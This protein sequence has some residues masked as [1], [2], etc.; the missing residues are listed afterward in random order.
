MT[1]VNDYNQGLIKLPI[2][3][4]TSMTAGQGLIWGVDATST[5]TCCLINMANKADNIFAILEE[6]PSLVASNIGTPLVYQ[7]LCSL[8]VNSRVHKVYYDQN[9]S[10]DLDVSSSTSTVLT[11]A[12]MDDNLDASWLYIQ[13]GTGAGQLRYIKAADTTT[14]TVNTAFTTTPD[15]TSD[16]II[17]RNVGI[18]T[19]GT[20]FNTTFDKFLAALDNTTAQKCIVLKN[21]CEG[22]FGVVEMDVNRNGFLEADGLQN[23]GV[24]FFSHI[25]FFDTEI[26]ATGL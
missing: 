26:A 22:P 14:L 8:V 16:F 2:Y 15:A 11:A 6:T 12:T 17:I 18:P 25:I 1:V 21:F 10:T 13:S 3:N 4:A 20:I 9:L 19:G 7:A 5:S 23:R 24:R